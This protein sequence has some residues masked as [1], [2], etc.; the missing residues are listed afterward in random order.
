M[1][2]H[3]IS[4]MSSQI[5]ISER[6]DY[7]SRGWMGTRLGLQSSASSRPSDWVYSGF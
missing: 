2:L 1:N 5:F 6:L 7:P 4:I 3:I